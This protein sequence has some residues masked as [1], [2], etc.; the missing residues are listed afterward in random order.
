MPIAAYSIARFPGVQTLVGSR[1][2][3]GNL[4]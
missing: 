1:S 4:R 2:I 3:I